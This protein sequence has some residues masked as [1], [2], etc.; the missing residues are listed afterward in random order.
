MLTPEL[1]N[2]GYISPV[3]KILGQKLMLLS[4]LK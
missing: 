4:I 3:L 2:D 1:Q